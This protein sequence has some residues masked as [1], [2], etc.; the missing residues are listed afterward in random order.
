MDR[1]KEQVVLVTGAGSG[2]GLECALF[3]AGHGY[4]VFGT[5]LDEAEAGRAGREAIQRGAG[6]EWL[7]MNLTRQEQINDGISTLLAR[8]G[9]LDALVHFAGVGLRGFFED[10]T[11]E[12]I[13][14][15]YD[16]NVF[17][18]M[19][20]VKC[21]L[22]HM[23]ARRSGRILLTTSVAGRMGSMS[24]SG[25]SSTKFALEGFGECVSQE[26]R[27]FGIYLSMLEPGLIAT[28]HFTVNRRQA[29]HSLDPSSP[30][31][32]WFR[33]HE[34]IVDRILVRRQFTPVDV[35][36]TVVRFL[37]ARRPRLRYVVGR[38]AKL[39]LN[40]RRYIP[41]EWFDRIYWPVLRRMVTTPQ[42]AGKPPE[43]E[44]PAASL[45]RAPQGKETKLR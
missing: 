23:R 34:E 44:T 21:V 24:I 3:L 35:A 29:R 36:R 18:A 41:G 30:Y 15:T 42:N 26:V 11:L 32:E 19:A 2:M 5:V 14:E 28:P 39:V 33:R 37:T 9:R 12:E 13:R 8:T 43:A 25:Y 45:A 1:P 17:G 38:N 20:L 16:V 22:P 27:P 10:L 31:A 7:R 4:R 6:I 40:L